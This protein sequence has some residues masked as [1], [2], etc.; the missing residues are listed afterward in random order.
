[1]S[2]H[3]RPVDEE[4]Q[5]ELPL[6]EA[7]CSLSIGLDLDHGLLELLSSEHSREASLSCL[8]TPLAAN[9]NS[10]RP[11]C[12]G[13]FLQCR[14]NNERANSRDRSSDGS[15][16]GSR[17]SGCLVVVVVSLFMLSRLLR[18]WCEEAPTGG[19]FP[20]F[21]HEPRARSHPDRRPGL[22]DGPCFAAG[23]RPPNFQSGHSR[24]APG[25]CR[26]APQGEK[27]D[28]FKPSDCA[29][30]FFFSSTCCSF[31]STPARV[32]GPFSGVDPR[33]WNFRR[34]CSSNG[35]GQIAGSPTG[36]E[37]GRLGLSSY[38]LRFGVIVSNTVTT[39]LLRRAEWR[40]KT[41]SRGALYAPT[42]PCAWS[43]APSAMHQWIAFRV[44][45][46]RKVARECC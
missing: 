6:R 16:R 30:S 43:F 20:C 32:R 1:M 31:F 4:T 5:L 34:T 35:R 38:H 28:V 36:K 40:G 42:C 29:P 27:C 14:S 8:T 2:F 44:R 21:G 46:M 25:G 17:S 41:I 24:L 12:N 37:V 18:A 23:L 7:P 39:R 19:G 33:T 3:H 9:S 10:P 22:C 26:V 11:Y 15:G 13:T 45:R